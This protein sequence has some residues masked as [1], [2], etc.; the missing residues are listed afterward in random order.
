MTFDGIGNKY[1]PLDKI[2]RQKEK[3]KREIQVDLFEFLY[4]L[5]FIFFLS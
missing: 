1:I 3:L 2:R 5:I 4:F